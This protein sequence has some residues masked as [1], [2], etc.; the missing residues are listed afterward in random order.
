MKKRLKKS[1][2]GLFFSSLNAWKLTKRIVKRFH[3]TDRWIFGQKSKNLVSV[4]GCVEFEFFFRLVFLI[5][6]IFLS[7]QHIQLDAWDFI[8]RAKMWISD[9]GFWLEIGTTFFP[10][11]SKTFC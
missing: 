5:C 3:F 9:F 2:G 1:F 4:S 8:S 6:G 10:A 7:S 11:F